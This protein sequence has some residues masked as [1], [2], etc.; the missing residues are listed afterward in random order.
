MVSDKDKSILLV[1]VGGQ[2]SILASKIFCEVAFKSG[3]D[4]K[5]SELHGLARRGGAVHSHIRFGEKVWSPLVRRKETDLIVA[6]EELEALRWVAYARPGGHFVVNSMQIVPSIA[7]SGMVEYPSDPIKTLKSCG[8]KPL[9][10]DATSAALKSGSLVFL[11]M[12][13]LGYI[14][15]LLEFSVSVWEE[16]AMESV[17][18]FK[19]KNWDAFLKGKKLKKR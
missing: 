9:V 19:E 1:G 8:V 2:G 12:V 4:V 6:F 15:N 14:S 16:V 17:P 18:K 7:S 13:M 3:Y 10:I 5:K 11:S